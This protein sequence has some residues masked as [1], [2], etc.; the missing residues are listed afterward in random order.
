[1]EASVTCPGVAW[2]GKWGRRGG[3]D[4]RACAR[5]GGGSTT[6]PW[7]EDTHTHPLPRRQVRVPAHRLRSSALGVVPRVER[8]DHVGEG[9]LLQPAGRRRRLRP[10]REP[11]RRARRLETRVAGDW[12]LDH[13]PFSQ[14]ARPAATAGGRVRPALRLGQP[15]FDERPAHLVG[16]G[17]VGRGGGRAWVLLWLGLHRQGEGAREL[18]LGRPGVV[19]RTNGQCVSVKARGL[20][21]GPVVDATVNHASP[22]WAPDRLLQECLFTPSRL[23]QAGSRRQAPLQ[24]GASP[25]A[26]RGKRRGRARSPA[27]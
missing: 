13:P 16:P 12:H 23:Q 6:R 24:R 17:A 22:A 25:A 26:L 19:R 3:W 2:G 11:V 1:M 20:V 27:R 7:P 14:P 18:G 10:P 5:E 8:V 9:D 4:V 21:R 15:G